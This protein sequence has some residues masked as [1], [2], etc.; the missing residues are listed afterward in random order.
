MLPGEE[1]GGGK[2]RG[3]RSPYEIKSQGRK[4]QKGSAMKIKI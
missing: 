3:T 2:V 1:S 4:F